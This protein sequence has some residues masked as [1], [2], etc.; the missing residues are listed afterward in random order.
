MNKKIAKKTFSY[1]PSIA[2]L[3]IVGSIRIG[4]NWSF[5]IIYL[6]FSCLAIMVSLQINLL[7]TNQ[8]RAK[9]YSLT[10]TPIVILFTFIIS[11]LGN[12][13]AMMWAPIGVVFIL[14][15][16]SP[17]WI[18]SSVFMYKLTQKH[19]KNIFNLITPI[20]PPVVKRK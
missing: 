6:L 5:S 14:L 17:V 18:L 15:Y 20:R 9:I 16:T 19:D 10:L 3:A 7:S 4:T 8:S 11:C 2:T 13:E 1:L 12:H